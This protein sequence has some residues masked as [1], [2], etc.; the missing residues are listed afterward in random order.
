[1]ISGAD[2]EISVSFGWQ[3]PQY[4]VLTVG[5]IGVST[6]GLEFFYKEAPPSMKTASASLF[7]LTTAVGDIMGD[8][9]YDF[10]ADA[11]RVNNATLLFFCAILIFAA[12][13]NEY[14]KRHWGGQM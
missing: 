10:F 1:M 3:L 7:L 5:E 14:E 9:L 2:E 13:A 12:F 11:F 8:L 4:F 6:T